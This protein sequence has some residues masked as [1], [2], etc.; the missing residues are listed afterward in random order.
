[1]VVIEDTGERLLRKVNYLLTVRDNGGFKKFILEINES[2][3][4]Y[5]LAD[6]IFYTDLDR[7]DRIIYLTPFF[8]RISP[9]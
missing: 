5:I 6:C 3:T 9:C 2:A 4:T 7:I 8:R 1:M